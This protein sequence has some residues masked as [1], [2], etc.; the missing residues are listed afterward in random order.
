MR[1]TNELAADFVTLQI[2]VIGEIGG[3]SRLRNLSHRQAVI[4]GVTTSL[5]EIFLFHNQLPD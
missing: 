1:H 4:R 5:R 3:L 2:F